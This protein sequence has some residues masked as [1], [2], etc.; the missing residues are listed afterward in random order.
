MSFGN[1]LVQYGVPETPGRCGES[2]YA[3]H[4]PPLLRLD[5]EAAMRI[6]DQEGAAQQLER[7]KALAP[8]HVETAYLEAEWHRKGGAAG[9]ATE[10]IPLYRRAITLDA[11]FAPAWRGLGLSLGSVG[12]TREGSIALQ[13]YLDLNPVATDRAHMLQLISTWT[14]LDS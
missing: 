9:A 5:L 6:G 4:L 11:S 3:R 12:D 8:Y 14:S 1:L 13:H 7:L 10:A 2:D